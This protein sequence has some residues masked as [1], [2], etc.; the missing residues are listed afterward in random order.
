MKK[1]T[2]SPYAVEAVE[3]V[4]FRG[5]DAS[6]NKVLHDP[7]YVKFSNNV[8][9]FKQREMTARTGQRKSGPPRLELFVPFDDG[10]ADDH[11]FRKRAI[12]EQSGPPI[13]GGRGKFDG[14]SYV[15]YA[16]KLP[17]APRL[18]HVVCKARIALS[19]YPVFPT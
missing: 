13:E 11:S 14:A 4:G 8:V 17:F 1:K 10:T 18:F 15:V 19:E 5:V 16:G 7:A 6:D 9:S 3:V 12:L 2:Y